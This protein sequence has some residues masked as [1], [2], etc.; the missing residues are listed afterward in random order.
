V[1][2]RG[3][4]LHPDA[5]VFVF[6]NRRRADDWDVIADF[7]PGKDKIDVS[8]TEKFGGADFDELLAAA[9]Q[10]GSHVVID[11]GHGTL[12]LEGV[13]LGDLDAEDFIF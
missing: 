9:S 4:A 3:L 7:R 12:K 8:R 2:H 10:S 13:D 11:M 1:A 6:H 5:D